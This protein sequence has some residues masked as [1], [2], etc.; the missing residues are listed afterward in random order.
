MWGGGTGLEGFQGGG[1]G[2]VL[3]R[4]GLDG[5]S[6]R[7]EDEGGRVSGVRGGRGGEEKGE[8][9]LGEEEGAFAVFWAGGR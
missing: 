2:G 7:T 4:C 3:I 1:G 9:G 5:G 8:G 6:G